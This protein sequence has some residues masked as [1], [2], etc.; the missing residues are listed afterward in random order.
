M[1]VLGLGTGDWM[2]K[3]AIPSPGA[4]GEHDAARRAR[5]AQQ[6]DNAGKDQS[7]VLL[8][9]DTKHYRSLPRMPGYFRRAFPRDSGAR[10][11]SAPLLRYFRAVSGGGP[12]KAD[13]GRS[14]SSRHRWETDGT[15]RLLPSA[16]NQNKLK[17][18]LMAKR[19]QMQEKRYVAPKKTERLAQMVKK[20]SCLLTVKSLRYMN[21]IVD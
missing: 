12:G 20:F 11:S 4:T 18:C 7:V 6:A 9:L 8:V 21:Q 1:L 17:F 16:G 5:S 2:V 15:C 13:I 14:A 3:G 19:Y 10:R